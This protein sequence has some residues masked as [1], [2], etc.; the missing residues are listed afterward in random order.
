MK[1]RRKR[2]RRGKR[3]VWEKGKRGVEKRKKR[4][5]GKGKEGLR[6]EKEGVRRGKR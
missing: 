4:D 5:W 1:S 3:E 6:R 2:L